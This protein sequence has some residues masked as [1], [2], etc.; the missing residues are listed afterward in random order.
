VAQE[1]LPVNSCLSSR[2]PCPGAHNKTSRAAVVIYSLGDVVCWLLSPKLFH[3][4]FWKPCLLR[5]L[6]HDVDLSCFSPP[7]LTNAGIG[8]K[9]ND[10]LWNLGNGRES[11]CRAHKCIRKLADNLL[12]LEKWCRASESASCKHKKPW[13]VRCSYQ[14][15]SCL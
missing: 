10:K 5:S 11:K 2:T 15:P 6:G 8:K 13:R 3:A 7:A 12:Y 14:I 4:H 1:L 9:K